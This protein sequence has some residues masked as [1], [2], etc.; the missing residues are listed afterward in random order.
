[1]SQR[2]ARIR[3]EVRYTNP[4][5]W[6]RVEVP[7][8]FT[9]EDFHSVIQAAFDWDGDHLWGFQLGKADL[10]KFRSVGRFG[11][12]PEGAYEVQLEAL[13]N[14]GVKKL[15]YIYDYGD[16]WEHLITIMR[17]LDADPKT[18]YPNLVAGANCAPIEDI[19]GVGGFYDFVE[20][21]LNPNHPSREHFEE[22]FGEKE[23]KE[24]DHEHF[25]ADLVKSRFAR[26]P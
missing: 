12:G 15:T 4:K 10:S 25:D 26:F 14:R 23:L 3:I 16:H 18:K 20:A 6:R 13:V 7:L 1:M 8:S 5:I 17:V 2:V 24:F 11:W 9:L 22:W 21:T 19:G